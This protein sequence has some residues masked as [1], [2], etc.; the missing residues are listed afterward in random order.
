LWE[1]S[2]LLLGTSFVKRSWAAGQ[3]K[4]LIQEKGREEVFCWKGIDDGKVFEF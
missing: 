1:A 2:V 4:Y 3:R